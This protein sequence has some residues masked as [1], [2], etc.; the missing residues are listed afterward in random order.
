MGRDRAG[1][2]GAGRRAALASALLALGLAACAPGR[3]DATPPRLDAGLRLAPPPEGV[4]GCWHGEVQPAVYET[5][6]D[7]VVAAPSVTD[8]AGRVLRPAA[9][10][11]E[12]R[13]RLVRERRPVWFA[14]P[15]AADGAGTAGFNATLQ[16]ALKAR[17][18][19]DAPL[20][21]EIDAATRVAIRRFQAGAGLDSDTLSLAAAQ[22]L[23]LVPR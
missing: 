1:G 20:T 5:V 2:A 13:Q 15:C 10:V 8:A 12:S 17:G 3:P 21:G 16:R 22:A 9:L 7:Q 4:A 11:S 23:G 14:V 19:Y 6:T 18:L